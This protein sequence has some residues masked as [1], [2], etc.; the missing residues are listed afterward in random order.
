MT[1]RPHVFV[2]AV[3][4]VPVFFATGARAD[5]AAVFEKN[6]A[7]CHGA[8]GQSDTPAGKAMKVPTLA[9]DANVTG[10]SVDDLFT[11]V[12]GIE[13]HAAML[14]KVGDEDLKSAIEHAKSLA[15]AK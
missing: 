14:K 4:A 1:T 11:K 8:S 6:C 13:K 12:K 10:A 3:L 9:G 7:M 15:A 5:G 2:A